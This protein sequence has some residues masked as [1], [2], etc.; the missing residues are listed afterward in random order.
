[1]YRPKHKVPK[2]HREETSKA[3]DTAD[4]VNK[5]P[6][7]HTSTLAGPSSKPPSK[8]LKTLSPSTPSL[9]GS[10]S[11][12]L[13]IP[14][15]V[16]IPASRSRRPFAT[17]AKP[18][19]RP[20]LRVPNELLVD[21]FY[22][23][24]LCPNPERNVEKRETE[25]QAF[26]RNY[27]HR[28]DNYRAMALVCRSW[29]PI[30]TRGL[31]DMVVLGG[32][33]KSESV[34]AQ[35]EELN[36]HQ[37]TSQIVVKWHHRLDAFNINILHRLTVLQPPKIFLLQLLRLHTAVPIPLPPLD[38]DFAARLTVLNITLGLGEMADLAPGTTVK[39]KLKS[40]KLSVTLMHQEF[41]ELIRAVLAWNTIEHLE[42]GYPRS[43]HPDD[44]AWRTY[45]PA[46]T[47][48]RSI[49][50]DAEVPA[51]IPSILA[52]ASNLE[53]VSFNRCPRIDVVK[54]LLS[55][56]G[57]NEPASITTLRLMASPYELTRTPLDLVVVDAPGVPAVMEALAS[58][59]RD[60]KAAGALKRVELWK[61]LDMT[62]EVP[63]AIKLPWKEKG[64]AAL[65]A[66]KAEERIK[67]FEKEV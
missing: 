65:K 16:P 23:A 4:L 49:V 36:R 52:H 27:I 58:E 41:A 59:I 22:F 60:G 17:R 34:L 13:P 26:T 18:L 45:L 20:F 57:R 1:M 6:P 12:S 7:S 39:C 63:T 28:Q 44:A 47:S 53:S 21:I 62:L 46:L 25:E 42:V 30:A 19:Y 51:S 2:N 15:P 37:P 50:L 55:A 9:P 33:I 54:D 48:L 66:L 40:F 10:S 61:K 32:S 24:A 3:A 31:I 67:I 5:A 29:A 8:K 43:F 14:I 35:L 64:W 11:T 56:P 38:G